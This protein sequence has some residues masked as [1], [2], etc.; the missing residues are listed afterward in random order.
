VGATA[1]KGQVLLCCSSRRR[2]C[3]R[4]RVDMPFAT[5]RAEAGGGNDARQLSARAYGGWCLGSRLVK[6][7]S[8]RRIP[9]NKAQGGLRQAKWACHALAW[10]NCLNPRQSQLS[11]QAKDQWGWMGLRREVESPPAGS[12]HPALDSW[13]ESKKAEDRERATSPESGPIGFVPARVCCG[14]ARG[15]GAGAGAETS[16]RGAYK[17]KYRKYRVDDARQLAARAYGGWCLGPGL[18]KPT[19]HR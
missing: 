16:G 12:F 1:Q 11:A 6:P 8:H 15:A 13:T 4:Q 7:T 17:Y 19:S 2:C 14:G 18:M 5:K 3:R 10:C 9:S